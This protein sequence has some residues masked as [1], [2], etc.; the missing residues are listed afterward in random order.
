MYELATINTTSLTN[1]KLAK[2]LNTIQKCILTVGKS[3]WG[4]AKSVDIIMNDELYKDDFE[5]DKQFADVLG[6]SKSSLSKA[7]RSVQ[8]VK[9]F[10][11][12]RDENGNPIYSLSKVEEMLPVAVD[13]FNDF[14]TGYEIYPSLTTKEIREAVQCY[15]EDKK[16]IESGA[17]GETES[18]SSNEEMM[19]EIRETDKKYKVTVP[20]D[21]DNGNVSYE[22]I[23]IAESDLL[24]LLNYIGGLRNE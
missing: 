12:L 10:D 6:I 19:E 5:T 20:S 1:K 9:E 4:F 8:R 2:E 21:F 11:C 14:I 3:E 17:D 15:K 13:D 22:D 16:A 7:Q 18:E 23:E 24:Q